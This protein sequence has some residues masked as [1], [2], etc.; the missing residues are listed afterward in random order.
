LDHYTTPPVLFNMVSTTAL[1]ITYALSPPEG[2]TPLNASTSGTLNYPPP[3][4]S[5]SQSPSSIST[6]DFY[7][8]TSAAVL[9]AQADLNA[10][11]TLWKDAIG[12]KE[13]HRED[14]GVVPH[15]QGRAVRMTKGITLVN[16]LEE[17]EGVMAG[18]ELD[19][20]DDDGTA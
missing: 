18:A 12:D 8:S 20:S 2:I 10:V 11:L 15:G 17:D 9:Q 1:Q 3:S 13:K 7:A 16:K 6:K 19:S 4:T 5:S 14:L